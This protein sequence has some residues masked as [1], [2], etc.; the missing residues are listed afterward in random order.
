M[1]KSTYLLKLPTSVKTAAARLAKA[2]GVSLNQFIA[3]AVA[4]KVG[5]NETAREVLEQRAPSMRSQRTCSS[6]CAGQGRSGRPNRTAD[7]SWMKS[8][9]A[10]RSL[11]RAGLSG[12]RMWRTGSARGVASVNERRLACDHHLERPAESERR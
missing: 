7:G 10:S 9:P 1:S 12:T 3:S 11:T 6:T 8:G 5:V 2:E 4:E